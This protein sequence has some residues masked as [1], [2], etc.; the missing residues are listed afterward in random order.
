MSGCPFVS[1]YSNSFASQCGWW[2]PALRMSAIDLSP[3]KAITD[4]SNSF[5]FP[6]SNSYVSLAGGVWLSGC[7]LP[8]ASK[9][10]QLLPSLLHL[11]SS[12][13]STH[14]P[15]VVSQLSPRCL[16]DAVAKMLSPSCPPM[17]LH[18]LVS[19]PVVAKMWSLSC[20][21]HVVSQVL[22][23]SCFQRFYICCLVFHLSPRCGLPVVSQMWFPRCC[24][25]VR[26]F[27]VVFWVFCRC[28]LP[29]VS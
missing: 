9:A 21:P 5:V 16:P 25:T 14:L 18:L 23:P 10:S 13:P 19:R 2:C 26:W 29:V 28:G 12:L 27:W 24:L 4:V 20:L 6:Y 1:P 8:V 7:R 11:L 15:D 3:I 22:S 17:F